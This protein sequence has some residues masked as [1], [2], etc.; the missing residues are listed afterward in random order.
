MVSPGT[1]SGSSV[2][3]ST[4]PRRLM[5]GIARPT[6]TETRTQQ[7]PTTSASHRLSVIGSIQA[8]VAKSSSYQ[9]SVSGCGMPESGRSLND[10]TT[11]QTSGI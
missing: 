1:K 9:R 10:M 8:E 3:S 6:G 5:R 4:P 2:I 11:S 7:M